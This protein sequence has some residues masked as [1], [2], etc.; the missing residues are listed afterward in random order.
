M[1]IDDLIV[2]A[3]DNII[4]SSTIGR[5]KKLISGVLLKPLLKEMNMSFQN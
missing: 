2:G 5:N 3:I 1:N 4:V